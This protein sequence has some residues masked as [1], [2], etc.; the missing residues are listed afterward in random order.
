MRELRGISVIWEA[1]GLAVASILPNPIPDKTRM[2]SLLSGGHEY[3]CLL[4]IPGNHSRI[5]PTC[6]FEF[7]YLL[8]FSSFR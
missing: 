6:K 2:A 7:I 5:P 1:C 4:H 8:I 3:R